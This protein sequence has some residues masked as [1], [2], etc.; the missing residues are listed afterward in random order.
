VLRP[1]AGSEELILHGA[2]GPSG[3]VHALD[4]GQEDLAGRHAGGLVE[5][6]DLGLLPV[7]DDDLVSLDL[8]LDGDAG[9]LG[10]LEDVQRHV[11]EDLDLLGG[12]GLVQADEECVL[13]GGPVH[14]VRDLGNGDDLL[15]LLRLLVVSRELQHA[16]LPGFGDVDVDG[17]LPEYLPHARWMIVAIVK[18]DGTD[19]Q[20]STFY[21]HGFE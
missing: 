6:D 13:L 19:T 15:E 20:L 17:V 10:G 21:I 9:V 18:P 16:G 12:H 1:G 2:V 11:G 8:V 7:G 5:A 14:E 3:S 4:D